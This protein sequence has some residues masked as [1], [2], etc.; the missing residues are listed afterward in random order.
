MAAELDGGVLGQAAHRPLGGAV[1]GM[2]GQG[3]EAG[4]GGDVDDR[5]GAPG[6][7]VLVDGPQA[8][9]HAELVDPAVEVDQ[10]YGQFFE[11]GRW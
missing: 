2:A 4:D 6:L 3:P 10:I 1:G 5:P 8:Q 7:H 11:G 9:E